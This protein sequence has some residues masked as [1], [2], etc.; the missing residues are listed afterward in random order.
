[1][2]YIKKRWDEFPDSFVT[3]TE[4][5][6]THSEMVEIPMMARHARARRL[7]F[8]R[9]KQALRVASKTDDYAKTLLA[10]ADPLL[11]GVSPQKAEEDEQ[12]I[13][14]IEQN[15]MDLA[16]KASGI[17]FDF[18]FGARRKME[19]EA[20]AEEAAAQEE[21]AKEQNLVQEVANML[22]LQKMGLG[23]VVEESS[24]IGVEQEDDLYTGEI[25]PEPQP[26]AEK[27]APDELTPPMSWAEALKE[28][29]K[30]GRRKKE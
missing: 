10:I 15:P 23:T 12:A 1:M 11:I 21:A 3:I 30:Q 13:L 18:E 4:W 27:L 6:M 28:K 20:R 16:L 19:Q 25:V 17:D 29:R 22:K 9:F 5:F 14:R 2:A 24:E 26:K 7:E 8:Y